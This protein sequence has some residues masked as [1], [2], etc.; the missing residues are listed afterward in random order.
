M[1]AIDWN[2][3]LSLMA[4]IERIVPESTFL[5]DTFFP[6]TPTPAFTN[7]IAVEYMKGGKKLAPFIVDGAQGVNIAREKSR[8]DIY[9][10]PMIAPRRT[11]TE[12]DI[13]GRGFGE[14][15]ISTISPA[16]RAAAAQA[17]DLRELQSA[18]RRRKNKM[19]ADILTTGKCVINGYADDGKQVKID[20]V[21]FDFETIITPTTAWTDTENAKPLDDIEAASIKIRQAAGIVPT[22]AIV[23][24]DVTKR[25]LENKSVR[26]YLMIPNRQ[27]LALMNFAPQLQSPY[28]TY[29]GVIPALGLD[30]Y[31]YIES[32]MDDDGEVKPYLPDDDFIIGIPG[33]GFQLHGA[34]TLVDAA[35]KSFQTYSSQY[36]PKLRADENSNTLSLAVY[37]RCVLAPE[38]V[39]DWA[40]IHTKG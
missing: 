28:L 33:K 16:Q 37:S 22:V 12:T 13:K 10:P 18:I 39:D 7:E 4:A 31:S 32:Y 23:G 15:P 26:D 29:V 24:A 2:D 5:L 30:V 34:V 40:V 11:L 3:T 35:S 14:T 20:E 36:V 17:R 19:A 9:K 25:L 27:N 38:S 21:S 1:P 6:N 8:L